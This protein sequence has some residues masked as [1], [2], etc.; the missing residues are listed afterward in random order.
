MRT[1]FIMWLHTHI[2][3]YSKHLLHK[4]QAVSKKIIC[5]KKIPNAYKNN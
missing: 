2:L 3:D 1:L 5:F 4:N